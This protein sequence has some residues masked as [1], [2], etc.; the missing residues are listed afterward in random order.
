MKKFAWI[1]LGSILLTGCSTYQEVSMMTTYSEEEP[2]SMYGKE[3]AEDVGS[4]A[5]YVVEDTILNQTK[6]VADAFNKKYNDYYYE[7]D[8]S[9]R[10]LQIDWEFLGFKTL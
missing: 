6:R 3:E 9:G 2:S 7:F 4:Q 5:Y 10:A 1:L 8:S